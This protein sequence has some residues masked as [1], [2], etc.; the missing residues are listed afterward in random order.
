[1]FCRQSSSLVNVYTCVGILQVV[2]L[3]L[4]LC[5]MMILLMNTYKQFILFGSINFVIFKDTIISSLE[6][7]SNIRLVSHLK[8]PLASKL[9]YTI[10]IY[11]N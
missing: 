8:C 7:T 9:F 2:I 3:N 10:N 11:K 6:L 4:V 1:M 5:L